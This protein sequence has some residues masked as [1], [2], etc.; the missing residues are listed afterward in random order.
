MPKLLSRRPTGQDA[1]DRAASC[2]VAGRAR[3]TGRL[4]PDSRAGRDRRDL[5]RERA[6]E[7]ALLPAA[8][9]LPAV[10]DD[11]GLE[12]DALDNAPGVHS[13]RW[14]G[15]DYAVK[16]AAIYRELL[17]AGRR[18]QPGA[19]R[20]PHRLAHGG[21]HPVRGDGTSKARSRRSRAA[22]TASATTP[23]SSIRPTDSPWP[24]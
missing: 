12:I 15:T 2:G 6:A 17:R 7:G 19:V 8:T 20:R 23:S 24:K 3:H 1:G 14:H 10:A 13:A 21:S 16:F 11:S 22:A 4:R 18:D 9:G 5:R